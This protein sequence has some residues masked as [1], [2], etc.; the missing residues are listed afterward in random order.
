MP[1]PSCTRRSL[2]VGLRK[3]SARYAAPRR[4]PEDCV[5]LAPQCDTMGQFVTDAECMAACRPGPRQERGRHASPRLNVDVGNRGGHG[6]RSLK[7]HDAPAHT[8]TSWRGLRV[9]EFTCRRASCRCGDPT[10]LG[11]ARFVALELL[12][13]APTTETGHRNAGLVTPH[14]A[15]AQACAGG[16]NNRT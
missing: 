1:T 14:I 7:A 16:G 4:V 11:L 6:N 15:R 9:S 3:G 2:V 5:A 8:R 12:A 10:W 13:S